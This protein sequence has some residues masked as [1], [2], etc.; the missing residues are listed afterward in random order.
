MLVRVLARVPARA[1]AKCRLIPAKSCQ[2]KNLLF[3]L[4]ICPAAAPLPARPLPTKTAQ[5]DPRRTTILPTTLAHLTSTL[6]NLAGNPSHQQPDGKTSRPM[7]LA[8]GLPGCI[9]AASR[10]PQSCC[11][12]AGLLACLPARLPSAMTMAI[13]MMM[14]MINWQTRARSMQS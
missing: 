7:P 6:P 11:M 8:T 2:A 13:V 4:L 3:S 14:M 1:Q 5:T 12:P 9:L 10:L